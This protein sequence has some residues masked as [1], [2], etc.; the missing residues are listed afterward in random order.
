MWHRYSGEREDG[1]NGTPAFKKI[2]VR[3]FGLESAHMETA[4]M[5]FPQGQSGRSYLTSGPGALPSNAAMVLT[6]EADMLAAASNRSDVTPVINCAMVSAIFIAVN[7][8]PGA[9]PFL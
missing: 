7:L 5:F 6:S 4:G 3:A 2:K 9:F 1:H 8:S